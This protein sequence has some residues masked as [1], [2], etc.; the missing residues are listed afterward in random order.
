MEHILQPTDVR[1]LG[2]PIGKVA[3]EKLMAF[4][5]EAEQLHIKPVFGDELFLR[6]LDSNEKDNNEIATLL[7]GGTY[8]DKRDGLRSFMGLK[9]A[10]SYFVYAQ[11][12]MSCDIESTRFGSVM[13]NGDFSTHISSKE[14]SDAYNNAVDVAKAYLRECVEYCKEIGL[15]KVVGRAKYN[16]GGVTIRKIGK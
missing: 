16:V 12:L 11:N 15:I 10:L 8:K 1:S 14:R 9:V 7:N 3:D 4:I 6:I 5:T 2:R 13:K